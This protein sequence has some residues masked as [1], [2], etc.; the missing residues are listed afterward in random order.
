[1]LL[2]LGPKYDMG[3]LAPKEGD[4]WARAAKGTDWCMWIKLHDEQQ[5]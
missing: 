3:A 1:V 2:K 4:G 5:A